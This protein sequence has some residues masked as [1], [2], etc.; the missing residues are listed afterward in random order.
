[1]NKAKVLEKLDKAWLE[2][3][4]SFAGLPE[5]KMAEQGVTGD[6]SVKDLLAHVHWWEQETLTSLPVI[7]AGG[8]TPRY[9]Q[10]YGGLDAFNTLMTEKYRNRP[11]HDIRKQLEAS[12]QDLVSYLKSL[13]EEKFLTQ[14]RLVRRLRN[15]TYGHYPEHT[16]AILEWRKQKGL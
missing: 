9:S 5:R 8:R 15:D 2:F 14:E 13:P 3:N 12:H 1:M 11:L 6:W 10:L 7:L 16:R 4:R